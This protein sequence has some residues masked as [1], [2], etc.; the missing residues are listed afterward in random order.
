MLRTKAV[1]LAKVEASYGQDAAPTPGANAILTDLPEFEVLGRKLERNNT[2]SYFGHLPPVNVG[3]G[4]KI[5]F[6]AELKGSGAVDTPP[7]IGAL[8]R[9]CNFTE[10]IT[11]STGPVDYDPNSST[12]GES[13]SIYFYQDGILHKLLGCRGT[14][15]FELKAGEYGA[16]PF[17]LT[18][19]YAGPADDTAP[20]GTYNQTV[21]PKFLSANF[22]IDSYSG[23]IES[24]KA[25]MNNEIAKRVSANAATG[26]LEYM[27]RQRKVSGECDPEAVTLATKD[28][29]QMWE[30]SS[31]VAL[32][33]T[34]GATAGN[35]CVITAPKV[36]LDVP[37]YGDREGILT[38][39]LPLVFT[40]DTG[41]DEI[42]FS[43]Q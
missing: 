21:P 39:S 17:E 5:R 12:S 15:G 11:P 32:S 35:K 1:V 24:L 18:G 22:T 23:V 31:A 36:V 29:W 4:L 34:V 37:K 41:D 13:A 20:S 30:D 19:I 10:T 14:F 9:A 7:E 8:L 26:I 40:P 25:E 3:E 33:A 38:Y 28:F 16:V 6:K 27:I 2:R 42:K 43:F